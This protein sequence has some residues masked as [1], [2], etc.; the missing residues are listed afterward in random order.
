MK[1]IKTSEALPKSGRYVLAWLEGAKIPMRAMWAAQHTLPLGDDADP[2][3]GEYSEEKDEYF[4]PAGWYEM[5]QFEEQHWGVSGNV[6]A[7]C[8]LPRLDHQCLAQIEEPAQPVLYVSPG[9]LANHSNPEGPESEKAGRYLP[10][11]KTPAGKFIQPLYAGAAPAD[12]APR[13]RDLL[14]IVRT[15][16]SEA[17]RLINGEDSGSDLA[18]TKLDLPETLRVL[19][20]ALSRPAAVAGS[21]VGVKFFSASNEGLDEHDTAEAAQNEA[22]SIIDMYREEAADGWPE[23]VDSVCW[24]VILGKAVERPVKDAPFMAGILGSDMEPVDYVLEPVAAP[25]LEAPAAPAGDLALI[26]AA[27]EHGQPQMAH[28]AEPCERHA[29][30]L[31]AAR[32]LAAAPQAPAEAQ[33]PAANLHDDGYWTPTKTEAGRALNERLMRAGSPRIPVYTHPAPRQAA[34]QAPNCTP[35]S[36][37]GED[38]EGYLT[39]GRGPDDHTV[40]GPC[41][42]CDGTGAAPQAPAAP[43]A[44]EGVAQFR[45]RPV[46]ISAIQWTGKNLREV[47]TFTDGPPE[48]RGTHAG[49]AWEA[50]TDLVERDGLM[51]YTLEGKMHASVG[52]WIIRGVKGEHYPCKPDIF[53]ETYEPVAAAPAAPAVDASGAVPVVLGKKLFQF[54]CHQDWVNRAQ[55]AWK[56]AGVRSE[57]TICLDQKGRVLRKGLEFARADKEGAFPVVVYL[58]LVDDTAAHDAWLAAQAAAKGASDE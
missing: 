41:R 47:I 28:Y 5:N 9:Q 35:C 38:P 1:I 21:A 49:M 36:G 34:P 19:E 48:T 14:G 17:R 8:E 13:A 25:A 37:S 24:G 30:A 15:A 22:Q 45:K 57:D 55:R 18:Q 2:E 4:C 56:M 42:S 20:H 32:R 53:A 12:G 44:V 23:E 16:Q 7:W 27:L 10:A 29:K 26:I 54:S 46:T 51:I 43:S 39:H 6:V 31:A 40:D 11:R 33:E 3:W 50:Y 52:D 58:A